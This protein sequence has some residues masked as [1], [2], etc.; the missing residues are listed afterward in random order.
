MILYD[1]IDV[2][3]SYD[4][5]GFDKIKRLIL[6]LNKIRFENKILS[7]GLV[8]NFRELCGRKSK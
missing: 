8:S 3:I 6:L 7:C 4:F 2:V 5:C 1:L